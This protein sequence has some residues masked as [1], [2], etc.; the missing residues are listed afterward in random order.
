MFHDLN[1]LWPVPFAT[2][3]GGAAGTGGKKGK[4]NKGGSG[5]GQSSK[6]DAK[7]ILVGR[8]R[9]DLRSLTMDA[10]DLGFH[11]IAYNFIVR[12][13]FDGAIHSNPFAAEQQ[14][15]QFNVP[16][17]DLETRNKKGKQAISPDSTVRQLT[18]MTL[19]LDEDSMG[20]HG[21]GLTNT[22]Q[23]A[24]MGYD[25]LSAQ[26]CND[27]SFSTLCLSL[28]ELK[29]FSIDIITLDFASH[30]RAPFYMKRSLVNAAIQNG[31]VFEVCYSRAVSGVNNGEDAK[32]RR[33]II[34][35]TREL[36]RMTNGK[37][38]IISSGASDLMGLRGP[39]DVINFASVLGMNPMAAK[40]AI[41]STCRSLLLRA[42]TRK[43]FRGVVGSVEVVMPTNT[44]VSKRKDR[45]DE[46]I[47]EKE[48]IG[49][50]MGKKKK[51]KK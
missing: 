27:Q 6:V 26:P 23:T 29:P 47:K 19:V 17:P 32:A 9:D 8:Q 10:A 24:L 3:K 46:P 12:S 36:M 15:D 1:I 44:G 30:S 4:E 39:Y 11:T 43:T 48:E 31:A 49:I 35:S 22:N 16:F 25:L 41:T 40:D 14:L 18:R 21:H 7:D 33:N 34:S 51:S 45:E 50:T 13:R 20:K 28:T 38:I 2:Q 37:G 5:S 42:E